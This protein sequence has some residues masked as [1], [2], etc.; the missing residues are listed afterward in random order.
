MTS[1]VTFTS[2]RSA[3]L[4]FCQ[5]TDIDIKHNHLLKPKVTSDTLDV[6]MIRAYDKATEIIM[7]RRM[8]WP[9]K[10]YPNP[11]ALQA[12]FEVPE[13]ICAMTLRYKRV[14]KVIIECGIFAPGNWA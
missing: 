10:V 14:I 7:L 1:Y 2:I 9:I 3:W 8:H 5:Y 13:L 4:H 6:D 12:L 11:A